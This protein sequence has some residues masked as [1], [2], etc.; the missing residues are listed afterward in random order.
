MS[1]IPDLLRRPDVQVTPTTEAVI[2]ALCQKLPASPP[3]T[4]LELWRTGGQ[5]AL[6]SLDAEILGPAELLRDLEENDWVGRIVAQGLLPFY[7]DHQSNYLAVHLRPPL[8]ER[9]RAVPHDSDPSLLYRSFDRFVDALLAGLD[10]PGFTSDSFGLESDDYADYQV[11]GPRT[12][13]DLQ[14]ARAL[15][16]T[17][18]EDEW[19]EAVPLLSP[20]NTAE[21]KLLLEKEGYARRCALAWLEQFDLPWVQELLER[22]RGEF[23]AW[24]DRLAAACRAAGFTVEEKDSF[25]LKVGGSWLNLPVFY[26]RRNARDAMPRTILWIGDLIA[27]RHPRHRA[28]HLM[29]D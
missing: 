21:W 14:A 11:K 28:D 13:D 16:A 17:D 12:Q 29:I 10:T 19:S 20:D 18:N 15:L 6:V 5:V 1:R 2:A 4:L 8:A 24:V 25:S 3:L 27:K 7:D 9:V 23:S 26:A 22:E